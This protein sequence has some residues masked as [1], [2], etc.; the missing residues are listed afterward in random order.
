MLDYTQ[1]L[2]RLKNSQKIKPGIIFQCFASQGYVTIHR[3]VYLNIGMLTAYI[4]M[5][6]KNTEREIEGKRKTSKHQKKT[7]FVMLI[8]KKSDSNNNFL[9]EM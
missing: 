4:E 2:V 1:K 9:L 3:N 7:Q 5:K 6:W 8:N